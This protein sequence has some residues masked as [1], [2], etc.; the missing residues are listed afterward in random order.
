MEGK[1]QPLSYGRPPCR[2]Y[3]LHRYWAL[4]NECTKELKME[5]EVHHGPE[6]LYRVDLSGLGR[7][8]VIDPANIHASQ[9]DPP[10]LSKPGKNS[11]DQNILHLHGKAE[12]GYG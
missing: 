7:H 12:D 1:P 4:D 5:L 6:F 3:P 9:R 2:N 11:A 8:R 10:V